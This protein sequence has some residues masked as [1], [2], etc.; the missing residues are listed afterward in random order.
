MAREHCARASTLDRTHPEL[1]ALWPRVEAAR[2][3][4]V[5]ARLLFERGLDARP[6]DTR[7]LNVSCWA[8][9]GLSGLRAGRGKGWGL[10]A[11]RVRGREGRAREVEAGK[12]ASVVCVWGVASE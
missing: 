3:D 2:G 7:L 6:T 9:S 8:P 5:K 1:L 10:R 12:R 4:R 11:G